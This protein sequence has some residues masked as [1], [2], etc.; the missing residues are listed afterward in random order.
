MNAR[1][2]EDVSDEGE[3]WDCLAAPFPLIPALSLRERE[4]G[5][6]SRFQNDDIGFDGRAGT[7]TN[8]AQD[9]AEF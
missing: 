6:P 9:L 1:I 7:M 2:G 5:T 4:K 3:D 8:A